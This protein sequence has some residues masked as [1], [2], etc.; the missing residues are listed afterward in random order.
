MQGL[1]S[2]SKIPAPAT[3]ASIVGPVIFSVLHQ[4]HQP[5]TTPA[6]SHPGPSDK[7][8]ATRTN[9]LNHPAAPSA[10]LS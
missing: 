5:L 4:E 10:L 8:L 7:G 9:A 6:R 3:T 2:P 1:A